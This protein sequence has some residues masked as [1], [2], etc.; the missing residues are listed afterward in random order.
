MTHHPGLLCLAFVFAAGASLA[1][2]TRPGQWSVDIATSADGQ[3]WGGTHTVKQCVSAKDAAQPV[4]QTLQKIVSEA[5]QSGCR[6]LSL[7]AGGGQASGRFECEQPG[8]SPATI[9]VEGTY[10]SDTYN[11]KFAASNLKDR[12]GGGTRI[13]K[14]YMKQQGRHTGACAG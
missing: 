4:E 11:F 9:D 1:E 5:A 13:A 6:A 14:F 2:T 12:N 3:K 10:A 8:G 7:K